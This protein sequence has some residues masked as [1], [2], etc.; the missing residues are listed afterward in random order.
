MR[1][2]VLLLL[3]GPAWAQ[4]APGSEMMRGMEKM[5]QEM[6][7]APL[8]G[9]ADHDFVSMLV[10]HYRGAVEMAQTYLKSGRDPD[11]RKLANE[12]VE[13]QTREVRF[14]RGWQAKHMAPR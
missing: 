12:I 8:N 2:L 1:Y 7:A 9:N 13:S 3:A 5:N 14:M 10:P 6:M 4:P 11:I